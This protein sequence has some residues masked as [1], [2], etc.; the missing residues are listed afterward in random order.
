[1][2]I[3]NGSKDLKGDQKNLVSKEVGD[4][5]VEGGKGGSVQGILDDKV[6][7]VEL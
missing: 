3:W 6:K 5:I 4:V 7:S 1:M 2:K